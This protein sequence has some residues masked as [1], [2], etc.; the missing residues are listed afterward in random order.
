MKSNWLSR[1]VSRKDAD[2]KKRAVV[3]YLLC[4]AAAAVVNAAGY[5]GSL[6]AAAALLLA[7]ALLAFLLFACFAMTM[8]ATAMLAVSE[9]LKKHGKIRIVVTD[10]DDEDEPW[11]ASLRTDDEIEEDEREEAV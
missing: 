1:L 11:K 7:A 10:E 6:D 9:T 2:F 8:L 4:L 5:K 3:V